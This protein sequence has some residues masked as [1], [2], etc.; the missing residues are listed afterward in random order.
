MGWPVK[1]WSFRRLNRG[2]P[3]RLKNTWVVHPAVDNITY[4]FTVSQFLIN[5][6]SS[7]PL[8]IQLILPNPTIFLLAIQIIGAAF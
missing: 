4:N 5:T 7:L 1:N 6:I 2:K 3:T 8:D